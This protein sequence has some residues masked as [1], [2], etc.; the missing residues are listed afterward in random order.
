[1]RLSF[2]LITLAFIVIPG[3]SRDQNRLQVDVSDVKMAD[4]KIRRY[5]HDLFTVNLNHLRSDLE[6]LKPAYP[7][8][9][10]TDLGD[11][12]KLN[13]M[14]DYLASPRNLEFYAAVDSQYRDIQEVETDLTK[15]FRHLLYYYPGTLVPRVYA[16]ISGGDYDFPVQFADSVMLIGLDNFLG[17]DFKP[18]EADGLPVYRVSRMNRAN[19]VP[20]CMNVI[21]KILYPEQVP[22]NNLL[23]QMVEAGKRRLFLDAMMPEADDRIKIG[24]TPEQYNWIV[25]N[26]VHVWEAI[27]DNRMLFSTDGKLIRTFM[28]DGPFTAEFSK[29]SPPRLGEWLGWQI[30]KKYYANQSESTLQQVMTEQD[31]QK[32][33]RLSDYKPGK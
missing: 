27:I 22:G 17:K 2:I 33:L 30:V 11:T 28:A 3:C 9:L 19:I 12:A 8:F 29:D 20:Q 15:A 16:Y 4:I 25:K 1:M 13:S 14:M 26:E 18:Y 7:F 23:E 6:R 10:G 24:Y 5:D 21:C 32:I 31:V